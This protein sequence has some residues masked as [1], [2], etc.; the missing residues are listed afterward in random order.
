MHHELGGFAR[1][2]LQEYSLLGV[3]RLSE[4]AALQ[5]RAGWTLCVQGHCTALGL[6]WGC[7]SASLPLV[8]AP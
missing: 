6:L 5:V 2:V 7:C 4:P 8:K 3:S 1:Q